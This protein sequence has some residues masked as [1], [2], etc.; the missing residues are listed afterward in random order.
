MSEV[1]L[2]ELNAEQRLDWLRLWRSENVG[3]ITFGQ[4]LA[5][6]G[7]ARAAL[8]AVPEL[9][10]RGGRR[11][12]IRICSAAEA[13]R[14]VAATRAAGA[15][16]V[17]LCEPDYP[18]PLAAIPDAP[19][20]LAV[21]GHAHLFAERTIAIVGARNASAAGV[22]FARDISRE[23]GQLGFVIASGLARGIDTV[24]HEGALESGTVAVLAGGIDVV[25]PAENEGLYGTIVE[26]GAVIAEQPV[27]KQPQGRHFPSRNR[28]ISGLSLGVL[29]VEAALR[30]G[31]LI[32]ARMALE[33]NREVFAVPGSPLDPR[34]RGS[35]RLIRDGA[36]LI[37]TA[38]HVI[39]ALE[40]LALPRLAEAEPE[41]FPAAPAAPASEPEVAGSR[42]LV[43]GKLCPTP[44]GVDEILR[45]CRLTPAVLLTILLELELAGRLQRHPGN[46]ISLL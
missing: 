4:L 9:A 36:A 18:R 41:L 32:T 42:D 31:S 20:L 6:F 28:L 23:L 39:E 25:Y 24:A 7:S 26:Q 34:C 43:A 46:Q 1:E 40:N 14:E 35:N 27:G 2:G 38:D 11:G 30:S 15:R 5:R 37:E 8:E 3:P 12:A 16:L 22:R 44:I 19:P 13:E 17:A 29:V 45:Q 10:R 21:K 33:Q